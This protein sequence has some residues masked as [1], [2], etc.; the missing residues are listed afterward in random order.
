MSPV[1]TVISCLLKYYCASA[2]PATV[3][4]R[5]RVAP[6]CGARLEG[7]KEHHAALHMLMQ[8]AKPAARG[9]ATRSN[10]QMEGSYDPRTSFILWICLR[11]CSQ[12]WQSHLGR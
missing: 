7:W 5:E 4:E 3:K 11:L 2:F 8:Q 6:V 10:I 12:G 9:G 1:T